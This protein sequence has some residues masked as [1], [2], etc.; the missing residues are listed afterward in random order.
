[1][2]YIACNLDLSH[3]AVGFCLLVCFSFVSFLPVCRTVI[4]ICLSRERSYLWEKASSFLVR[5]HLLLRGPGTAI[6]LKIESWIVPLVF[7]F[8]CYLWNQKTVLDEIS[9]VLLPFILRESLL[10]C[11]RKPFPS[12]GR[13]CDRSQPLSICDNFGLQVLLRQRRIKRWQGAHQTMGMKRCSQSF[14]YR[15]HRKVSFPCSSI[16]LW[17][18]WGWFPK[19]G[20]KQRSGVLASWTSLCA[21]MSCLHLAPETGDCTAWVPRE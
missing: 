3:W 18:E 6:D 9:D 17:K 12:E 20:R 15:T 8:Y 1:M 11:E 13:L 2:F 19:Q 21:R 10:N 4:R 14:V 5:T 16:S 7:N